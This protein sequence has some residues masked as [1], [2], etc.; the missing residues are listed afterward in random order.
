VQDE[1]EV[2]QEKMWCQDNKGTLKMTSNDVGVLAR[3]RDFFN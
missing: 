3:G 1:T 2:D